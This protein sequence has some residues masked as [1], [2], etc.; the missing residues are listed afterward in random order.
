KGGRLGFDSFKPLGH[1]FH[2]LDAGWIALRADQHEIVVHDGVALNAKTVGDKFL[3]LRLG[4]HE[5]NVGVTAPSTIKRLTCSLP[6]DFDPDGGL[7]FEKRQ[8]VTE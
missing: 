4:V 5:Q 2:A 3:L 6:N 7:G 1:V 8:N